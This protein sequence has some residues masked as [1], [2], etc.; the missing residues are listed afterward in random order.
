MPRDHLSDTQLGEIYEQHA[1]RVTPKASRAYGTGSI[2]SLF[3]KQG[4]N[5]LYERY[6]KPRV[7]A[8]GLD[9]AEYMHSIADRETIP[10]NRAPLGSAK[11]SIPYDKGLVSSELSHPIREARVKDFDPRHVMGTQPWIL[12]GAT[13][14][15]LE[16]GRNAPLYSDQDQVGNQMPFVYVHKG[17]GELRLLAGHHRASAALIKG[18]PLTA[19]YAIGE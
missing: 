13:R 10:W 12:S 3:S 4:L 19:R 5:P 17:S 15:Y 7:E 11:K 9:P 1:N 16:G 18:E 6:A 8:L 14:H 2:Y